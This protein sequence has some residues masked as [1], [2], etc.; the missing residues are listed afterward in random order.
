MGRD[1]E[2]NTRRR[3]TTRGAPSTE[4][5]KQRGNMSR[6]QSPDKLKEGVGVGVG[7]RV[8]GGGGGGPGEGGED[9]DAQTCAVFLLRPGGG[10]E[11][12]RGRLSKPKGFK[13]GRPSS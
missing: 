7:L 1:G 5:K 12:S 10:E 13:V 9:S 6:N 4:A 8:W 11:R 2:T 3:E